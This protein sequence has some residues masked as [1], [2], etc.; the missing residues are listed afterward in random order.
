MLRITI[1]R[2][3]RVTKFRLEGKLRGEWVRELERCWAD[4]RKAC[5]QKQFVIDLRSV[6]LVDERGK[7]LLTHM[8][9]QG[10]TLEPGDSLMMSSLV[11]QIL[12]VPTR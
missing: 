4:A 9:F 6:D 3:A 8:A 2:N 7:D 12:H 11:E 5:A 10:A 1:E